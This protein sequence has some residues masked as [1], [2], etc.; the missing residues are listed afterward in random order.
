MYRNNIECFSLFWKSTRATVRYSLGLL[1]PPNV[2]KP[3]GSL[4][5][6]NRGS[7]TSARDWRENSLGST[8]FRANPFVPNG[9]LNVTS[10]PLWQAAEANS[11]KSPASIF[12]VGT[13]DRLS[14]GVERWMVACSP[15]KKNTLFFT[16]GPPKVPPNW[17]R[18]RPSLLVA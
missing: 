3:Q 14:V 13:N 6:G 4:D 7:L 8:V 17:L 16:I 2:V 12:A 10:L 11:V 1:T 15:T 18:F 9:P 5:R